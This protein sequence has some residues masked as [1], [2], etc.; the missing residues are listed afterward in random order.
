[1]H[2]GRRI[3]LHVDM[4]AFFAQAEVLAVPSLRGKPL[5]IGG[6]P[7]QRGVVA[8]ASYE[9]RPFGIRSG[10]SLTEAARLCP[11]AAFL[12]CHPN[13][14]FDLSARI[15]RLLLKRTPVVEMASID[16]AYLD[17]TKLVGS[18]AEGEKLAHSIQEDLQQE[19][20]LS[21][22]VGI[23]PNKL[24]AKMAAGMRK[25]AGRTAL[26]RA[27]FLELFSRKPVTALYGVGRA[28]A[29]A[30]SRHGIT[31]IEELARAP[32][33]HLRR[34]LGIWGSV[35]KAAARG[36]DASPVVPHHARPDAKSLGHEYT[37]PADESDPRMLRRWLLGICEEVG[38][39]LREEDRVGDTIHL[40]VRWMDFTLCS[41][42][43]RLREPTA[44]TRRI[45]G[46]ACS[47][48]DKLGYDRAFRLLGVSVSGLRTPT[49]A[50]TVD[51]FED[52]KLDAFDRAADR[53]RQRYG[54][55]TFRRATLLPEE[56]G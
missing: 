17:A 40:K 16:E 47:L 14:Y 31:R 13:R 29:A 3:I 19:L 43:H 56:K 41:R 36:E 54:R 48:L 46:V 42:Q 23:G 51:M 50:S 7:G 52:T 53:I 12:P 4:D 6:L 1:M 5:I 45:F 11:H 20:S 30:L 39:D 25:P 18:L 2:P 34:L 22:S 35:L 49:G 27:K 28:T 24:I 55:R 26:D 44:S 37:L 9:A 8:T 33:N 32:E 15:L 10:M 38:S 21:C